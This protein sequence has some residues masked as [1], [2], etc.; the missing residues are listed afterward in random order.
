MPV[1]TLS[2][3]ELD[4]IVTLIAPEW[5]IG[6]ATPL[7]LGGHPVYRLLLETP[8]GEREC[9]AKATPDGAS[10]S[11]ALEARI[12]AVLD[13]HTTLPVPSVIGAIDDHEDLP[14]PVVLT[15]AMPGEASSRFELGSYP[16]DSLRAL[17]RATGRSLADLHALSAVDGF[18]FLTHRGPTLHGDRPSGD[19]DSIAVADPTDSWDEQLRAWTDDAIDA[20]AGT[21]F[22]DLA[23]HVED[24]MATRVD[25]LDGP[26]EPVLARIDQSLDN[27]LVDDGQLTALLDWE[28]TVAAT[29]AY[30]IA[31]VVFSLA[32][33]PY[34]YAAPMPDRRRSLR[35]AVLAGYRERGDGVIVE[36]A[37][38]NWPCYGLLTTLRAMVHLQDWFAGFDLDDE[39]DDAAAALREEVSGIA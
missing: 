19:L 2:D 21:R 16:E 38:S 6:D 8:A 7:E 31:H 1:E 17:A 4:R 39:L 9:Y 14:A 28:F 22:A 27:V 30:D 23:P 29:P 36:Q 24:V 32:G 5:R 34:L 11:V 13:R 20:L 3:D 10:Q 12:L 18:G 37:R 15:S 33:G 25:G 35:E 26:F